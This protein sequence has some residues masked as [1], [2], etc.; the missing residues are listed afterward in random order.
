MQTVEKN[1]CPHCGEHKRYMRVLY[2]KEM[3]EGH[4]SR[5]VQVE[6]PKCKSR[7]PL[8]TEDSGGRQLHGCPDREWMD[9]AFDAWT[10]RATKSL[11]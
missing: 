8:L 2:F 10:K 9:A 5:Q 7:G 3:V 4:E 6:C 11:S 1:F